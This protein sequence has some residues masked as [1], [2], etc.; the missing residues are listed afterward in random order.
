[1]SK[2]TPDR[3]APAPAPLQTV[4]LGQ[5]LDLKLAD[6]AP[7]LGR[8]LREGT[9]AMVH[10]R[11]GSG[12]TFLMLSMAI[13]AAY[14]VA[15]LGWEAQT[16]VPV[17]YIDGE[18]TA[19]DMQNRL[20]QLMA[21]VL[22]SID[23]SW[24]PLHLVT[25]DLQPHGIGKIDSTE[26]RAAV[27]D[28]VMSAGARILFLDNLSCLTNPE[29][30]N[31]ASSWSA[32]Q[33]LLLSLRRVGIAVVLGHHSGKNGEQRGTSR[34]ADILDVVLKL[35]PAT[36][37]EP[38]GCSRVQVEFEKARHLRAEEKE[39]FVATLASHPLGGLAWTRSAPVQAVGDRAREMLAHG[40]SP[41]EVAT[42]LN[43]GR[44]YVYRIRDEMHRTGELS[45]PKSSPKF[46]PR[47]L[48]PVPSLGEGTRGQQDVP[49]GQTQGTK[50]G[51]KGQQDG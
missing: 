3:I 7:V 37:V 36:D 14:G 24:Q 35:T 13:A 46:P 12:K 49:G 44:S 50:W 30:D 31:A 45:P 25:P 48:S 19:V 33:E 5:F 27:I 32:V 51:H 34:R 4:E 18:M 6:P 38:D 43:T 15:L 11:A 40:M 41:G 26:G 20:R 9:L 23:H 28:A 17:V 8:L 10:G 1:V 22:E 29:D 21:W 42:E 39:A 2:E 47:R 16:P